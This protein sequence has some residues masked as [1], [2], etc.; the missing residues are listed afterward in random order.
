MRK[1]FISTITPPIAKLLLV[2]FMCLPLWGGSL[3]AADQPYAVF[4]ATSGTLTFSYGEKPNGAYDLNKGINKPDWYNNRS[5]I[6]KVVFEASFANARPTSCYYWFYFCTKLTQIEGI[7]NLNTEEVTNMNYFFY[8]CKSLTSLNISKFNTAKVTDMNNMFAVCQNLKSLDVS[9]LNTEKVTNMKSMF[10]HCDKLTSLD[11]SNFNTE[12]VTDMSNMFNYCDN[13][14]I[15]YASDKF[16]T[17]K[18]QKSAS[19]FKNSTKL[20]GAIAYDVNK[21]DCT[22]ANYK[23][24]YFSKQVGMNGSEKIGAAGE[25]LTA[26]KLALA[27]DND[28]VAYEPFIAKEGTYSRSMKEG[29][30]WATLCLPFEVSLTGQNFRAFSILSVNEEG[31]IILQEK[32]YIEAGTPVFIKMNSGETQLKISV[33]NKTINRNA[34]ATSIENG[35]Y[36]FLGLYTKKVFSKEDDDNCYILKGYKLMN[37]AKLLE[38]E[39]T[40]SVGSKAFRA[41]MKDNSQTQAAGAKMF[42]IGIGDYT[43]A[44]NNLNAMANDKAEYY[45]LQGHRLNSPQKG[46]NIVKRGNK[47]MKVIIK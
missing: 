37:P 1:F 36:Q 14:T 11:V 28:F 23:T 34:I 35:N 47:T 5:N 33:K 24:G 15:I 29:T 42:S 27:D 25:V 39:N 46:V 31:T 6:N 17:T 26:E 38:N 3:W 9:I 43:T 10:L 13:L 2:I 32:S 30:M 20:K 40:K 16:V 8:S 22:Y 7:E 41:Y 12:N 19:M 44:I 45:D 21:T 18:V 4:D